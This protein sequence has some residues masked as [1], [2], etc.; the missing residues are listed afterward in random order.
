MME[1]KPKCFGHCFEESYYACVKKG[2]TELPALERM[3]SASARGL[4]LSPTYTL[5][6]ACPT[7]VDC[8]ME[9]IAN[10]KNTQKRQKET[11]SRKTRT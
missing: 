11:R 5:E 4:Y 6:V 7:F 1:R 10:A 9:T 8:A 3:R 2:A